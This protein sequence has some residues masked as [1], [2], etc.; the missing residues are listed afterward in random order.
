[1]I[2]LT[3]CSYHSKSY[4]H[5][6]EQVYIKMV[7][8]VGMCE[9]N[10]M[11]IYNKTFKTTHTCAKETIETIETI[12]TKAVP[13]AAAAAVGLGADQL[14]KYIGK[15][16]KKEADK[17]AAN[18]ES[19]LFIQDFWE[20]DGS[21][22]YYAI[23]L[24][25]K[26]NDDENE[27]F[28]DNAYEAYF[29]L[30]LDDS[31][32]FIWIYPLFFHTECAKPKVSK[33]KGE[34]SS[35][36]EL[37]FSSTWIDDKGTYHKQNLA[38]ITPLSIKT[39]SLKDRIIYTNCSTISDSNNKIRCKD[40]KNGDIKSISTVNTLPI[41]PITKGFIEKRI[42]KSYLWIKAKVTEIDTSKFV[43]YMTQA[44]E[45]IDK[46]RDKIVDGIKKQIT[47]K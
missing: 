11:G 40:N 45:G 37:A 21:L 12:E 5:N 6:D 4:Y 17:H 24:S 44:S 31:G 47:K 23:N 8:K 26:A 7:D 33:S 28:C 2:T 46:N 1:M 32:D 20:S 35:T 16:I 15:S 39:Y 43:E 10:L 9:K 3:G 41:V 19:E 36:T 34:I 13:P 18:F 14:L 42:N 38:D 25:R 29:G 22:K 27:Q 30:K